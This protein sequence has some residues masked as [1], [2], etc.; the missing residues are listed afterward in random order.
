VGANAYKGDMGQRREA[1]LR[2]RAAAVNI[3][4]RA[5]APPML[6]TLVT[7]PWPGLWEK[8]APHTA[9]APVTRPA[10]V[11]HLQLTRSGRLVS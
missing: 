8:Y 10:T 11:C 9:E 3:L 1:W 7:P 6:R 5:V 4:F 2:T